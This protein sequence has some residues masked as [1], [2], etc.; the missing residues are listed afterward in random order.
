MFLLLVSLQ[1]LIWSNSHVSF[2]GQFYKLSVSLTVTFLLL[3][4]LQAVSLL[5]LLVSQHC[6]IMRTGKVRS[7]PIIDNSSCVLSQDDFWYAEF[8]KGGKPA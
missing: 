8:F 4:S 6:C 1:A 2:A 5:L 7:T 3:V